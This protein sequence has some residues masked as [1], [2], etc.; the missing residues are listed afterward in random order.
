VSPGPERQV[1]TAHTKHL[2]TGGDWSAGEAGNTS[3]E[4]DELSSDSGRRSRRE[5]AA[6]ESQTCHTLSRAKRG[7]YCEHVDWHA[8]DPT[9][10][11]PGTDV[12]GEPVAANH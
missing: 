9:Y 5:F 3:R 6:P 4:R 12:A 10:V 7:A 1:G 2:G 8:F 11:P